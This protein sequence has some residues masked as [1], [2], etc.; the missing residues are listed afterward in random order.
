MIFVMVF[1]AG[2]AQSGRL[3]SGILYV[4]QDGDCGRKKPM[5]ETVQSVVD[6]AVSGDEICVDSGY[7]R[8]SVLVMV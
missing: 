1:L 8:I 3:D 6:E 5:L 7:S 4:A 2:M